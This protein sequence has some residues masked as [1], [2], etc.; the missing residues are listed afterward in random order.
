MSF[1]IPVDES[2]PWKGY[3]LVVPAVSVGNVGQLA[4]DLVISTL[5]MKKV[6]HIT[7]D[8]ITP[9]IGNDPYAG[10]FSSR[11][12]TLHLKPENGHTPSAPSLMTSCE[13]YE[14]SAHRVVVMQLRSP[15]IRGRKASFRN[16]LVAFIKEKQ[17]DQIVMLCSTHAHE[18][19]DQQ[20]RGDQFRY[21]ATDSFSARSV[22]SEALSSLGW[23]Q[24]ERRDSREE[25]GKDVN[26]YLPGGG[27]AKQLFLACERENIAMVSLMVFCSEGDNVPEA[28]SLADHLNDLMK[29]H[30]T[31]SR[32]SWRIPGSW[33]ALFGNRYAEN[34][35]VFG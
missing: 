24:L 30:D 35:L 8:S 22:H 12:G 4:A 14:S 16:K 1:Y 26:P 7:D 6:G 29:I 32:S 21:I 17:F 11:V 28:F 2:P 31:K 15:L 5:Q 9:V 18:R 20:L 13:L 19:L 25:V 33:S 27:I 23:T 3:T 10:C 34:E